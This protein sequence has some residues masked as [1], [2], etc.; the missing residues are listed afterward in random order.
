MNSDLLYQWMRQI[1]KAFPDLG[2]WQKLG[3]GLLSYG[4]ILA[5]SCTLSRIARGLSQGRMTETMERRLQRW[6]SNPRLVMATLFPCWIHWVLREWGEATVL[7]LVD[8]TKLSD[9]VS[10]MMVSLYYRQSAIPLIWRAYRPEDYPAEGQVGILRDL[11]ARL[12]LLLPEMTPAVLLADRGLG[13]SPAWQQV[14]TEQGWVYLLRVQ[15]T[16]RIRLPNG[17]AQALGHLVSYGQRWS[18][19]GQV[20]K[21][22]G[23]QWRSVYVVWEVGY[24]QP[25][26][27]VSNGSALSPDLYAWR[28]SQEAS[29]RDLKS[30]GFDW[31][32]SQIWQPAH[33]ERLLL[34][35]ALATLWTLA[36]GTIVTHLHPLTKRQQRLSVFRLG[37]D[38]LFVCLRALTQGCLELYF[39]PDTPLLKSVVP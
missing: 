18:G 15:R 33:V 25:W 6:L 9:H 12:R 34:G 31:Q 16:T 35:L 19:R 5:E 32:R 24:A 27:L 14:L 21:K 10:V 23:W 38:R 7:L 2:R 20:F 13:T 36:T 30:D 1:D 8:E 11:L 26:C 3:L 4:M 22:A 37:L 29:F 39:V 17:K 28:F